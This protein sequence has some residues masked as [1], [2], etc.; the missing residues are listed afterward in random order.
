MQLINVDAVQTQSPKASLNRF[1]E[2]RGRCIV[3]PLIRTGPV[4]TS[5]GGYYQ[6]SRVRK[7]RFGNQFLVY[8]W[9]VGIRGINEIDI[10]FHGPAK[11]C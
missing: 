8:V 4:P 10:K 7:Q 11:H 5:F 6:T 3:G 2:V 1:A 9:A